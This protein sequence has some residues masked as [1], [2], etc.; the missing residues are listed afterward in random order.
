MS[1]SENGRGPKE[2]R[3]WRTIKEEAARIH[4]H[5]ATLR[6]AIR[7]GKLRCVRVSGR[8]SI[9]LLPEWTDSYLLAAGP[10]IGG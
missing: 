6:L 3:R 1:K 7:A 9:R 10:S 2:L 5:P 4:V 8:R